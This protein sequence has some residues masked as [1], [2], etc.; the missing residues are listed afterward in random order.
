MGM[1]QGKRQIAGIDLSDGTRIE[2]EF[3]PS[4][5]L[6]FTPWPGS[7]ALALYLDQHADELELKNKRALELGSGSSSVCGFTAGHL[8]K[9]AT[10]TDRP[11]VIHALGDA[12]SRCGLLHRKVDIK[13]LDW[14]DMEFTVSAFRH[15]DVD[16]ILMTDV[17]YYDMLWPGLLNQ[18]LILSRA[19][20]LILWANCD[21]YP[22]FT[23]DVDKF[24]HLISEFFD[25]T[26]LE[27]RLQEGTGCPTGVYGGRVVTRRLTLRDEEQAQEA[28]EHTR[29][30]DCTRRCFF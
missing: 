14:N 16:M 15:E 21:K 22:K 11:E 24:L 4:D 7:F 20:T 12:A 30:R 8:C 1:G 23:P 3:N 28:L 19:S 26:V 27:D 2:V 5:G 18:L 29:S 17:V 9:F 10:L 6:G 13:V 25:V